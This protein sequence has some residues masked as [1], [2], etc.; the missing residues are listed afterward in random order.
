MMMIVENG[1][2]VIQLY[3]RLVMFGCSHVIYNSG[4]L[5]KFVFLHAAKFV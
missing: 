4:V 2:K 1:F 5:R 3:S